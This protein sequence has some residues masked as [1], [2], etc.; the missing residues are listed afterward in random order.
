MTNQ[1]ADLPVPAAGRAGTYTILLRDFSAT[2]ALAGRPG[3]PPVRISLRL[4]VTHPGPGFAD[5]ISAVMSYEDIVEDLRRLCAAETVP[6]PELLAERTADLCLSHAQVLTA[7]VEIELPSLF[8]PDVGAG[9]SLTR[10]Q[11]SKA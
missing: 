5:D 2:V 9:I 6:G 4:T 3:R 1:P 11:R 8:D 7:Q 10:V